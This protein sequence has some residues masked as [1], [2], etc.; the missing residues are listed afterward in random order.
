MLTLEN[1]K[2]E[3]VK[4]VV[5]D[6]ATLS[7][8]E[9]YLSDF[10]SFE[11]LPAGEHRKIHVQGV[12]FNIPS[13]T[14]FIFTFNFDVSTEEVTERFIDRTP[15]IPRSLIDTAPQGEIKFDDTFVGFS[16][17]FLNDYILEV[18]E[19]TN[20]TNQMRDE[21]EDEIELWQ[22]LPRLSLSTRKQK[23]INLFFQLM[24]NEDDSEYIKDFAASTFLLPLVRGYGQAYG[25]ALSEIISK[26]SL[27]RTKMRLQD[28]ADNGQSS[29][30]Y[31]YI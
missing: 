6:E 23:Q 16:A 20:N 4:T 13:T 27:R 5:F 17:D 12:T 2:D 14:R 31:R 15:I 3:P 28:V 24:E 25:E 10:L 19:K 7:P 11:C 21:F 29:A 9:H 18:N 8:L 1:D 22:T 30:S 26:T